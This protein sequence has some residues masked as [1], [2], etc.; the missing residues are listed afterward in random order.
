MPRVRLHTKLPTSITRTTAWNLPER[1]RLRYEREICRRKEFTVL[2]FEPADVGKLKVGS[3][4]GARS[5]APA[6]WRHLLQ[7]SSIWRAHADRQIQPSRFNWGC[8]YS[9]AGVHL[10][11]SPAAAARDHE[12]NPDLHSMRTWWDATCSW[13]MMD[14]LGD[15]K[16]R[17][18]QVQQWDRGRLPGPDVTRTDCLGCM[19]DRR[20]FYAP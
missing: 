14:N 13:F 8:C 16:D 12:G 1:P 18:K 3:G 20:Q 19:P 9:V 11:I 17:G 6:V 2:V 15:K 7:S 4:P 10:S 5:I